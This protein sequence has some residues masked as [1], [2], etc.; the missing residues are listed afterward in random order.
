LG[1]KEKRQLISLLQNS[2]KKQSITIDGKTVIADKG[3]ITMPSDA[4]EISAELVDIADDLLINY[5]SS[6]KGK[7]IIFNISEA[8]GFTQKLPYQ[9]KK[10]SK[11]VATEEQPLVKAGDIFY[12][13]W[14]YDQTNIDWYQVVSL[15]KSGKS[16]KVR[17]IAGKMKETGFMSGITVP[18][19]GKFSGS[20]ITKKIG[21]NNGEVFLKFPHGWT[22]KWDGKPKHASWG[23]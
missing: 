4:H 21:I 11:I 13:S 23:H 10:K 22:S 9:E 19:K 20:A 1:S 16:V 18:Q 14:G 2:N 7:N 5:K 12:N 17:P 3:I 8:M 6:T 15:T